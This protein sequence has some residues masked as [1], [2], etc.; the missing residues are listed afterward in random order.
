MPDVVKHG[1]TH[2]P[3]AL[4]GT[5]PIPAAEAAPVPVAQMSE[6][7]NSRTTGSKLLMT[8]G[9]FSTNDTSV[10]GYSNVTSSK[11]RFMTVAEDGIYRIDYQINWNS[12]F[13]AG[14]QPAIVALTEQGGVT[15]DL[16]PAMDRYWSIEGSQG[17]WNQQITAAEMDHWNLF[18]TA[19]IQYEAAMFG[20][21]PLKIGVGLYSNNSRTKNFAAQLSCYRVST[22]LMS[23]VTIT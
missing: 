15:G 1:W 7:Q 17:I 19:V 6:G 20:E 23:D 21:T 5:D 4:G 18:G 16:I 2:R 12:D 9:L 8:F 13:T 11:A 3:R 22:A 14:D 10:F